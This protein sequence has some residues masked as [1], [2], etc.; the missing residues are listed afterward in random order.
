M[1]T[2]EGMI[3]YCMAQT[4]GPCYDKD[5]GFEWK[6]GIVVDEDTADA[7][8][9]Q[10]PKQPAKKVKRSDFAA[11]FKTEPPEGDEKNLYVITLKKNTKLANGEDVPEKYQP[12]VFEEV[13]G[14]LVDITKM[15]LPG[16]GS[17]GQVSIDH[18]ANDYGA[19]ARLRNVKITHLVEYE[20]AQAGDEFSSGSS[21]E[22][23]KSNPKPTP[24]PAAKAP[25]PAKKQEVKETEKTGFDDM[26]DDIPF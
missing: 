15:K 23:K 24:K 12:K 2:L 26:D 11:E 18:W 13:D 25:A 1:K 21:K 4:A 10:Y 19:F 14:K 9:E 6:C 17:L 5:K 20:G 22:T 7:F 16:N 3:V 8:N